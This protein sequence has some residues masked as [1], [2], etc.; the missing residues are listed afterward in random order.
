MNIKLL[1]E[2]KR[3]IRENPERLAMSLWVNKGK[4]G[5]KVPAFEVDKDD[6]DVIPTDYVPHE[7]NRK[8]PKCGTVACIAG[9]TVELGLTEVA[10]SCNIEGIKQTAIMLLELDEPTASKL[11]FVNEWPKVYQDKFNKAKTP[12]GAAQITI[13]RINYFIKNEE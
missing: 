5:S 11:F 1:N 3:V 10:K 12:G 13:Q 4:A 7:L 2:V 8:Y 6:R 9:W